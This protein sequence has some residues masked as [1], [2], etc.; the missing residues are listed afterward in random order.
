MW[1][2]QVLNGGP[3]TLVLPKI[4]FA[5]W[6]LFLF[7]WRLSILVQP[8][9][10]LLLMLTTLFAFCLF[11]I[12]WC[13]CRKTHHFPCSISPVWHDN[14]IIIKTNGKAE[15]ESLLFHV[16]QRSRWKSSFIHLKMWIIASPSDHSSCFFSRLFTND[17]LIDKGQSI[18][19]GRHQRCNW[20]GAGF[21]CNCCQRW[22]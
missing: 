3:K 18:W 16:S 6:C 5:L 2:V 22:S 4:E 12:N 21:V 13:F 20:C 14:K 8:L 11:Q 10:L 9:K 1:K 19:C 17:S 15:F 7:L